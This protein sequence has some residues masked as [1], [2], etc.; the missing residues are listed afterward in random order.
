MIILEK[1]VLEKRLVC[2]KNE[3]TVLNV[4]ADAVRVI[5]NDQILRYRFALRKLVK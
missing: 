5:S 3:K 2:K 1:L 4:A